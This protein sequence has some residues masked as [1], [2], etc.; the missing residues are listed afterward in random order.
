MLL[1]F[2]M[3]KCPCVP[4]INSTWVFVFC[5]FG[6]I[7]INRIWPYKF[8]LLTTYDCKIQ[9]KMYILLKKIKISFI[10][11]FLQVCVKDYLFLANLTKLN[12]NT[13]AADDWLNFFIGY[14][15]EFSISIDE[16][17]LLAKSY[18]LYDKFLYPVIF[19]PWK[20]LWFYFICSSIP[21]NP[22]LTRTPL[23][24]YIL[25]CTIL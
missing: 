8:S 7:F 15:L 23:W 19:A 4:V 9:F 13:A 2:S 5:F 11:L 1:F 12:C 24:M 16:T 21:F 6:C 17:Y 18:S 20:P 14:W 3:L 22:L 25:V 10:L